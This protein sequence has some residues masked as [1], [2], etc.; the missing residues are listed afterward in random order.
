[1]RTRAA[2]PLDCYD[3]RGIAVRSAMED[4]EL[5]LQER[6]AELQKLERA[7][8]DRSCVE[9]ITTLVSSNNNK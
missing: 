5:G 9:A 2:G 8:R 4:E 7:A 6:K 1:M 3:E